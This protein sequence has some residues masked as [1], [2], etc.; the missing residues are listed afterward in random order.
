M[1]V[2]VFLVRN[3]R[4]K[5]ARKPPQGQFNSI[6]SERPLLQTSGQSYQHSRLNRRD[7]MPLR[8]MQIRTNPQ[9]EDSQVV[10]IF[11]TCKYNLNGLQ[12]NIKTCVI[13]S[14]A[15]TAR[16]ARTMK[17]KCYKLCHSL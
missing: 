5:I 6:G 10:D 7:K 9:Y 15:R 1:V 14:N 13:S 3:F 2:V 11:G 17:H 12:W 16:S 4:R 8:S